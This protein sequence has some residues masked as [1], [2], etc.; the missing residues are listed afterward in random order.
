MRALSG[1]A[2]RIAAAV[3]GC[4]ALLLPSHAAAAVPAET[5]Y[6]L[7]TLSFL[8]HGTLVLFMATGFTMLEGGLVRT[9][10][11]ST[12]LLKNVTLIALAAIGFWATGYNLMF[13]G[14]DGGLIGTFGPWSPDDAAARAGDYAGAAS[15]SGAGSTGADAP[16]SGAA[17]SVSAGGGGVGAAASAVFCA[18]ACVCCVGCVDPSRSPS[19]MPP[20]RPAISKPAPASA[21][22]G[23]GF[24]ASGSAT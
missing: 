15:A 19:R 8:I 4:A 21:P 1:N 9:K 14:V 17:R 18:S 2:P 16:G 10:S 22:H 12:I 23:R 11:V 7:N 5:Q 24:F 6:I 20:A 3:A 13:T